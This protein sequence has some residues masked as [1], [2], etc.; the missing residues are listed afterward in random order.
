M[1]AKYDKPV[2]LDLYCKAGGAT[3]GYQRA[4]FRVVGVDKDPQPNYCGD[5]FFQADALDV[6]EALLEERQV[7]L[8]WPTAIANLAAVHASPPC[9]AY[10]AFRWMR[11]GASSYPELIEP[12]REL[13]RALPRPYVIENVPGAPL[14]DPI[15][16]CG[17]MFGL[18]IAE[19]ELRR[20]R[21]FECSFPVEAPPRCFHPRGRKTLGIYG[22]GTRQSTRPALRNERGWLKGGA[23]DKANLRQAQELMEM[24]WA[25]RAEICQAIP[26]AYTEYIGRALMEHL[27]ASA[28]AI[29]A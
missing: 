24:P 19:G 1:T 9:Q 26:P 7:G 13:L 25:N 15:Q 14:I 5:E 22:G 4:G 3:R 21:L 11:P 29:T 27:A 8:L 20:H 16:L 28:K 2:L 17:S 10:T 12:T 6:L 23:T 18:A